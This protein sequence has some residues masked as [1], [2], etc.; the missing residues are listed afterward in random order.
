MPGT[1][2][3]RIPSSHRS[4]SGGRTAEYHR[5]CRQRRNP[6]HVFEEMSGKRRRLI[7]FIFDWLKYYSR[8]CRQLE[9][10]HA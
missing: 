5:Q 1:S 10:L 9:Y 6:E 7:S 8:P 4:M 3:T 2:A